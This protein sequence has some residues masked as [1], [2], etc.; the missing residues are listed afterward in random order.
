MD[1]E[2][3]KSA[4]AEGAHEPRATREPDHRDGIFGTWI[5]LGVGMMESTV[6][7]TGR[8]F[9]VTCGESQR[10]V[11]ATIDWSE[12]AQQAFYRMARQANRSVFELS[13]EMVSRTEQAALVVLRQG[14]HTGDRASELAAQAS[15]AVV[16][17]RGLNGSAVPTVA[18]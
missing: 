2:P 3:M 8:L 16:G 10:A 12:Q 11:E 9:R 5:A 4:H 13:S 14:Q 15:Q 6:R 17:S 18:R 7:T 1:V